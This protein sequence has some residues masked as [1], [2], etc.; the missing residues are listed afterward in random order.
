MA[1]HEAAVA[2]TVA[3]AAAAAAATSSSPKKAKGKKGGGKDGGK[4]LCHLWFHTG[5]VARN[6]LVFGKSAVDK[7]NKDKKGVYPPNFAV[8]FL[9]T[10]EAPA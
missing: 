2:A 1:A 9:L 8:E 5:F 4:K 6:F 3:A 10:K 7:A